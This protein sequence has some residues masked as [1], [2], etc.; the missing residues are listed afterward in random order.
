VGGTYLR[1]ELYTN[2]RRENSFREKT[3]NIGLVEWIED[4]LTQYNEIKSICVSFAGQVKDGVILHSPNI[5]IDR[6]DIKNYFEDKFD[7]E[8]F[9]QNDLNC[10]VLAEANYFKS[11]DVCALYVGTGLGLGVVSSSKLISGVDGVATELGHMPYKESPFVC[12][13]G[14]TNCVEL[15]GSGSALIRWKKY[16]KLDEDLTLKELKDMKS[17]IYKEFEKA[18]L[19]AIATTITIF[20]PEILVLG[21]GIILNNPDLVETIK[22]KIKEYAI[23][24]ALENLKIQ[25]TKLENATIKGALLLKDG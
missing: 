10:A 11:G 13:C 3:I 6:L 9:I 21:G 23:P 5:N 15:F 4:I 17:E 22:V 18:L 24:I 8:F 20:N 16:Y 7:V 2:D 25:Q 12:G 1:A 19:H 14:K